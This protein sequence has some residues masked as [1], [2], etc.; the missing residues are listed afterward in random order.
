MLGV[1]ATI[2]VKQGRAADFERVFRELAAEVRAREPG[3]LA[4]EMTRSRSEPNLYK[5]FEV[6]RDDAVTAHHTGTGYFQRLF[7]EMQRLVDGE[8]DIELLDVVR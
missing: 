5:A 3:V 1:I 2:R 4:Y 6:Y 8:M 7:G